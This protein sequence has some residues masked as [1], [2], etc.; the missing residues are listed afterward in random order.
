[1]KSK[2]GHAAPA[3]ELYVSPLFRGRRAFVERTCHRWFILSAEHGLV[4]PDQVLAPYD[5]TL[6]NAS[7][8]ERRAWSRRVA[9]A[10]ERELSSVAGLYFEVHAGAAYLNHGLVEILGRRGARIEN[11]TEGLSL[12][13]QLCFYR[14]RGAGISPSRSPSA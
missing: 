6:T 13:E 3:K 9:D 14:R 5:R 11:P 12:G 1:V 10:L 4:H 2:L 8:A 7:V